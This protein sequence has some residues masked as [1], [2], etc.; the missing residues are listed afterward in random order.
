MTLAPPGPAAL[1]E[2]CDA[3][4]ADFL[5][6]QRPGWSDPDREP[7]FRALRRFVLSGGKRLRPAFCYWGWCGAGGAGAD[8]AVVTVGAALEL[9][10]CF[11]LIHDDIMDRSDHRRGEAS[12]HRIFSSLHREL[13]WHGDSGPFGLYAAILSGDLCASWSDQL[14]SECDSPPQRL[15]AARELFQTMRAEAIAGQYLDLLAQVS[16]PSSAGGEASAIDRALRVIQLKTARYT[17]TRPLQIGGALAGADERLLDWYA[18]FGEPLGE[19]YQLRDDI[20]G[21]FG[22]PG[23]TGKPNLDDLREGKPTVLMAMTFARADANQL[24]RLRSLVG[25][26]DLDSD[27]A[28]VVAEIVTATGA[29]AETEA[30]IT[31][32]AAVALD[33]LARAPIEA[34]AREGLRDLARRAVDRVA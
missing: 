25:N 3:A 9:F 12:M 6:R 19:T 23:S 16:A 4:L 10:H 14:F 5:D 11:A 20:L 34:G 7:V 1:R 29:L 32:R 26:P 17:V 2:R 27:G 24:H 8:D 22:D 18:R 28:A 15:R 33:T 13:D 31:R 30:L 21:V